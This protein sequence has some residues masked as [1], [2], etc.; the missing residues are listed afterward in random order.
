VPELGYQRIS[1]RRALVGLISMRLPVVP[2]FSWPMMA[3][4]A[5]GGGDRD[6][7]GS[8]GVPGADAAGV[9]LDAGSGV[10]GFDAGADDEV[11]ADRPC[12]DLGDGQVGDVRVVDEERGRGGGIGLGPDLLPV[13]STATTRT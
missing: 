4:G 5:V 11:R 6:G 8:C 1:G 9:E 12:G 7:L 13:L 2:D 10:G 3:D